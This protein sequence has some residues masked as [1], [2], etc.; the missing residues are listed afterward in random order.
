[1]IKS[2]QK[3]IFVLNII[4]MGYSFLKDYNDPIV[5]NCD[6][7]IDVIK[8]R[9]KSQPNFTVFRFL[10]DGIN[11]EDSFTYK[12]LGDRSKAIGVELQQYGLK[13]DK[14]LLL[15]QPGLPYIASLYGCFYSGFVAVPAYPPRR[16]RGIDRVYT[17]IKDSGAKICLISQ[18][19][20]DDIKRNFKDDNLLSQLSWIIYENIESKKLTDFVET[21]VL[22]DDIALLQ[23]TSGSTGEPKGVMIT[24]MNLLYNSE[25]IR[26]TFGIKKNAIGVHWLPLFH[27]MG[28]IGGLM[29]AA[30][31]GVLN[32][33]MPPM[34]FLKNP[35]NFLKAIDKYGGTIAGGPNFAYDY[36]IDKTTEED[37]MGLDLSSVEVFFC[38]AEPIRKTTYE[39][40]TKAFQVSNVT[41]RQ[42]Y[43]CYGMAETTLIV[44]GG[45][46]DEKPKY[47][48]V[49]SQL[50][51]Q[52]KVSILDIENESSIS[53]VGSG[54]VWMDTKIEIVDPLTKKRC[55]YDEVGEIWI[56]GPTVAAG[57][58]N[59]PEETKR[60]FGAII[61]GTNEGPFLRTGDLGFFYDKELFITGRIKDLI[62]I[63][64]VN[65]YPNDIEF[66]IQNSIPE[67]RQ[68]GGA[69]FP[70]TDNNTE[71]LVVVQEIERTAMKN[72]DHGAIIDKI[73][74]I[75][76][77][78]H[79]LDVHSISLV[80]PGSIP[81][82]SSGKIK[83]R[84][85]KYEYLHDDLN[86]VSSWTKEN[87]LEDRI[88][89]THANAVPTEESI[90]EWVIGWISR[91]Q[92]IKPE[93]I[94]IKKNIMAY[95]VDSLAAVT[96]ETEISKQFGF[97]WH[98]SSFILN[99]TI[100]KLAQEG[101]EIY[102]ESMGE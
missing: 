29:Q 39:N 101:M 8:G 91:D 93:E 27:D 85:T 78:E 4:V 60:T 62:I 11:E 41:E 25:Y 100:E 21:E 74:E 23:Y 36:C 81:I 49:D 97:Q 12:Q 38:G 75:I 76:A 33:N 24:Q 44:T 42:L 40:F 20:Y 9:V 34:A 71:K 3:T 89:D 32:I 82:T 57:Y 16:N 84:Q 64:G 88:T 72:T 73:R 66:S 47:I 53:L 45:Y 50:L 86:I 15:F 95:G 14:V 5:Q 6:T 28:L 87:V 69:A 37:R 48:N 77:E 68:N 55:A 63:R 19:V 70:I 35:L 56:S 83:H 96:L 98:I 10:Q 90:K 65:H 54:H 26:Q 80:R 7:Y 51:S 43:S 46:I 30:Y 67:L 79:E 17:I 52:N 22:P 58:W 18:Q 1:M 61:E 94:D 31:A 59:K 13:G 92:K 2:D 102:I 99:P